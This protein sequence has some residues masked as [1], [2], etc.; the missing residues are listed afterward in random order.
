[1]KINWQQRRWLLIL[2][3][4][5]ILILIA[6]ASSKKSPQKHNNGTDAL[7]VET[8][9]VK[10]TLIEP[11]VTGFGRVRPKERWQALSEVSGRVIYRHPKLEKGKA[12]KAGT[13]LLKI[14]PIDYELKLAQ[15]RSD[16][17]SARAELS[18]TQLNDEKLV[19]SLRL[20]EQRLSVLQKE[21]KRKQGLLKSGSVSVSTVDA[22]QANVWAQEQKVLDVRNAVDQHPD[23]MAVAEAKVK[24]AQ[25]RL[26]EAER[27]LAKTTIILPFDARIAEETVEMQQVVAE[28]ESLVTAHRTDLM[29]I[30][31]Q[32]ALSDM[33]HFGQY[34]SPQL[35]E[36][37]FPDVQT[38]DLNAEASLYIGS[39]QFNWQGKLTSVGESIDPQGNTVTLIVDVAFD[40]KA[41]EPGK[42]PPLISDMY[43]QVKVKGAERPLLSVPSDALH[44][45]RLY[46]LEND[47]LVIRQVEVAFESN[48]RTVIRSG[49]SEGDV[50][51]LSDVIP[52]VPG[53]ALRTQAQSAQETAL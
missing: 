24:L 30:P 52:A 42:R 13:V 37:E 19:L 29:E 4:L 11:Y 14:D 47:K 22:E 26:S 15:A 1:M 51:V 44:G 53:R 16:L 12:L 7:L 20:E 34:L 32:V 21:L 6:L 41:F 39:K 48:G 27:K 33:R 17:N 35:I 3:A 5:G 2:P 25:A 40:Y 18:R 49:V 45:S 10:S 43:V 36:G 23:N 50:V 28:R 31:V 8:A 9:E 38:W 46:L